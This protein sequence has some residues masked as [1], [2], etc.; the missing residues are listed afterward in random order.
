MYAGQG[1]TYSITGRADSSETNVPC[2]SVEEAEA[3]TRHIQFDEAELK[4][5]E[6][7]FSDL[8]CAASEVE[9]TFPTKA[10]ATLPVKRLHNSR[11][12]SGSHYDD[13]ATTVSSL[14]SALDSG[15]TDKTAFDCVTNATGTD[16]NSGLTSSSEA[17]EDPDVRKAI[18]EVS[19]GVAF[20]VFT[21][22]LLLYSYL[23][24][25]LGL[26]ARIRWPSR[27]AHC[28]AVLFLM[29]SPNV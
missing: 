18:S 13:S 23:V 10:C 7:A 5:L 12:K 11:D 2:S 1:A 6:D 21:P 3:E 16:H 27:K 14:H 15:R 24:I 22:H 25:P 9:A 4:C 20:R 26:L 28:S 8:E 17:R 29:N 19:Y